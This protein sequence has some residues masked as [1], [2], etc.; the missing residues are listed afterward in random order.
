MRMEY[1]YSNMSISR[2][3]LTIF[4]LAGH[5]LPLVRDLSIV[6]VYERGKLSEFL[7]NVAE[8]VDTTRLGNQMNDQLFKA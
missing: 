6:D 5:V 1:L 8:S 3:G 4:T 2:M 7:R